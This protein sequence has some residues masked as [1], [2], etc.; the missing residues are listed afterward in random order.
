[1]TTG[2]TPKPLNVNKKSPVITIMTGDCNSKYQK[3]VRII[4]P[5]KWIAPP[6]RKLPNVKIDTLL[7]RLEKVH[8]TGANKWLSCCPAHNDKSPSLAIKLA[9]TDKVLLHCFAGCSVADI[10]ASVG[11]TLADLMPET[12]QRATVGRKLMPQIL[13]M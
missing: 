8:K 10:V 4:T 2:S 5:D 12:P 6:A 1:M 3:T 13:K 7:S 11:L 9:D